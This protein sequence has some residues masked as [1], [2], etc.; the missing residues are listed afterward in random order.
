[1]LSTEECKKIIFNLGIEFGVSPRLIS[2]RMLNA[3]DKCDMLNGDL[4]IVELRASVE[5]AKANGVFDIRTPLK[6]GIRKGCPNPRIPQ[7]E[8]EQGEK[9]FYRRPFFCPEW[10]LDCHRLKGKTCR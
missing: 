5:A 2:E 7:P 1:M 10:K 8:P 6:D 9:C 3:Q 4:T